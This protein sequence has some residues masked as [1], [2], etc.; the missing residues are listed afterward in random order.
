MYETLKSDRQTN[1]DMEFRLHG[2]AIRAHKI[3]FTTGSEYFRKA[4]RHNDKL[5]KR[6]LVDLTWFE[7]GDWIQP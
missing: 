6:E 5:N 2:K 7:L 4:V 3:V 1:T